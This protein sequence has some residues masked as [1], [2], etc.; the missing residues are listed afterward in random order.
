MKP[1]KVR[2]I[3]LHKT[4]KKF[5]DRIV[6]WFQR[7]S[8]TKILVASGG[9]LTFFFSVA[10]SIRTLYKE[11]A[12]ISSVP[13]L[14]IR[15]EQVLPTTN[16]ITMAQMAGLEA[17]VTV[18]QMHELATEATTFAVSF[19]VRNPTSRKVSLS[20]CILEIQ[21]SPS[22]KVRQSRTSLSH[23]AISS[24]K[25]E[26]P[27]VFTVDAGAT[28]IAERVFIFDGEKFEEPKSFSD[29]SE[30]QSKITCFNEEMK[31]LASKWRDPLPNK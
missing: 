14:S 11:Y 13:V 29:S 20:D 5:P 24:R 28:A 7:S 15:M 21:P 26:K 22:A 1:R 9:L 18:P 6:G 19:E 3:P 10:L 31:P 23:E 12:E 2:P 30:R 27:F 8:Y 25:A 17:S 4:P 16:V